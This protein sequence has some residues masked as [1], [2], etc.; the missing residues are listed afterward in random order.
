MSNLLKET[1]VQKVIH[2]ATLAMF[3]KASNSDWGLGQKIMTCSFYY[4]NNSKN[5][6]VILGIKIKE[7][8]MCFTSYSII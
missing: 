1:F 6:V 5:V 2:T 7:V 3:L 4:N 8:F